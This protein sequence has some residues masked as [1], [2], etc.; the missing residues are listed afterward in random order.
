MLFPSPFGPANIMC[1]SHF[2]LSSVKLMFSLSRNNNFSY[3]NFFVIESNNGDDEP[4]YRFLA[5]ARIFSGKI[6]KG[7]K[8]Y[9]LGP[10]HNPAEAIEQVC[11]I[12]ELW[13]YMSIISISFI[14]LTLYDF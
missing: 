9:V 1:F 10:K 13:I 3:Y 7:Q 11:L 8:L 5:F 6:K 14:E 2:S 4:G 12:L